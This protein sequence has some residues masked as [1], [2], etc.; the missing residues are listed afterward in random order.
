MKREIKTNSNFLRRG[1]YD[2]VSEFAE[3]TESDHSFLYDLLTEFRP[4]R[5]VEVGVAEGGTD[6]IILDWL[7]K[8]EL[9]DTEFFAVDLAEY[10][11][12]KKI[13]YVVSEWK[14]YLSNYEKYHLYTGCVVA[15][16][17]EE[18]CEDE[19]CDFCII[20]TSHIMPGEVL[21]LLAVLPFLKENGV[22][23]LHDVMLHHMSK[24]RC[25]ATQIA[26]DCIVGNKI[27]NWDS[28]KYPNI[29]AVQINE[30]TYKYSLDLVSALGIPWEYDPGPE[31]LEQYAKIVKKYYDDEAYGLFWKNIN[32]NLE[33]IQRNKVYFE[34]TIVELFDMICSNSVQRIFLYGA[35]QGMKRYLHILKSHNM[36]NLVYGILISDDQKR[37]EDYIEEIKVY[38]WSEIN[39]NKNTDV[40][41]NT[42]LGLEVDR[43]LADKEAAFIPAGVLLKDEAYFLLS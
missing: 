20:D 10:R 15:E 34:R 25:Y 21:D 42:V 6:A 22:I 28:E 36:K 31:I 38:K 18:I 35:G 11:G 7:S 14:E 9:S 24:N 39:Y 1:V 27:W 8:N 17:I 26:F 5:I 23:V 12:G 43:I 3:M 16:V 29:A 4:H 13:G 41:I 19:K 33:W 30:D 32:L 2:T 37:F 40:I